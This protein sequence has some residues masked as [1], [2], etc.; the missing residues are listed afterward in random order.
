LVDE[1]LGDYRLRSKASDT[2]ALGRRKSDVPWNTSEVFTSND[3]DHAGEEAY[4]WRQLGIFGIYCHSNEA[5][6]E[7]SGRYSCGV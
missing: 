5:S 7:E 3:F 2:Y 6:K 1:A 4:R